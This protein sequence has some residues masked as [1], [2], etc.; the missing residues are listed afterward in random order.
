M[1]KRSRIAALFIMLSIIVGIMPM[2]AVSAETG[3]AGVKI[4]YSVDGENFTEISGSAIPYVSG[5]SR[6]Q[7]EIELPDYTKYVYVKITGTP[8][9][10][11]AP[12][13]AHYWNNYRGPGG[14][15]ANDLIGN[16]GT[17]ATNSNQQCDCDIT[18]DKDSNG[19]FI[20]PIKSENGDIYLYFKDSS[21]NT[22]CYCLRFTAKQE[23]LTSFTSSCESTLGDVVFVGGAAANNDNGTITITTSRSKPSTIR[24]LG[25][26]SKS[27]VGTSIFMLPALGNSDKATDK[28]LFSFRADHGGKIY[29]LSDTECGGVYGGETDGWTCVNNG[30]E[31]AGISKTMVDDKAILQTSRAYNDYTN[32]DYFAWSIE[33]W[34]EPYTYE[35]RGYNLYRLE[36]PGVDGDT[37]LDT[38]DPSKASTKSAW[39]MV[40]AYEKEF[41]PGDLVEIKGMNHKSPDTTVFVKWD[42]E[43]IE[44]EKGPVT[45]EYSVDNNEFLT[46][47]DVSDSNRELTVELPE[48]AKYA[49]VKLTE[50]ENANPPSSVYT[51]W[52]IRGEDYITED[53]LVGTTGAMGG[54]A[55][56]Q[57][58]VPLDAQTSGDTYIVPIKNENGTLSFVYGGYDYSIKFVAKQPRLTELNDYT[59][60]ENSKK[61]IFVGGA[62]ANNDNGTLTESSAMG[63][64]AQHIRGIGNISPALIGASIFMMP[65]YTN[66]EGTIF[67]FRADCGGKVVVMND[68][69]IT[70]SD[71]STWELENNGTQ[72]DAGIISGSRV[73]KARTVNNYTNVGDY[74]AISIAWWCQG[75]YGGRDQLNT[76]RVSDPGLYNPTRSNSSAPSS[77]SDTAK[78]TRGAYG[79]CYCYS[80]DFAAGE[81]VE[82]PA[83]GNDSPDAAIFV[84]WNSD[85]QVGTRWKS[86]EVVS[87]ESDD[88]F[89]IK[90]KAKT[91]LTDAPADAM[92]YA[93][94]YSH[95]GELLDVYKTAYESGET[96]VTKHF[97]KD[98]DGTAPAYAKLYIWSGAEPISE[99]KK[100]LLNSKFD[101]D[102]IKVLAIGNSFSQDCVRRLRDIAAADDITITSYN[103][104]LAGRN[105]KG[106]YDAWN[107]TTAYR[108]QPEGVSPNP[109]TNITLKEFAVLEDWDYVMLQ[110]TTHYN[111][112][113]AGLWN[114]NPSDTENYWTTLKNG[115]AEYAPN[116]KR[117]VNATWT[118][119][120]ELSANVNDGMFDGGTPD[121]RGAYLAALLPNEQI[122]ADFYSTETRADG[123]K[124]FIPVGV[125]V[126]YLIRYYRFPEYVGDLDGT[127][128]NSSTTRAVYRDTTCHLTDNVGRVLAGLVWYEMLTGIPA[129]ENGY[130][131]DKLSR[132]DMEK[133]K[134]AAHYACQNYATYNPAEITPIASETYDAEITKSK[135][136]ADATIVI[137]H[138]DGSKSTT[139]YLGTEFE[140]NN[141][142][143]TV[144]IIGKNVTTQSDASDW[145]EIFDGAHGRL[146]FASHS[147]YHEY[148]G[149]T[150]EAHT[151]YFSGV[152]KEYPAGYM[153]QTIANERTRLNGLFP[154]ERILAFVKPGVTKPDGITTQLSTE[155]RQMIRDHYIAMRDTGGGVDTIPPENDY[156][157]KSLMAK[158]GECELAD[159]QAGLTSAI[160]KKGLLVYLFHAIEN[161]ASNITS[162]RSDVSV[163]LSDIGE[164]VAEGKVWSAKFDEAMQYGKEYGANP[165]ATVTA[166][167][168]ANNM[169]VS[170]TDEISKID[171]D[172]VGQFKGREMYD[173][174][175]TVKAQI[176]FDWDYVKL[177]QNYCN[178]AEIAKTF[179]EDGIRYA[180]L[181]VVPDQAAATVTEATAN[182]YISSVSYGGTAISDFDP[183][184][185]YYNI[186]LPAGTAAAPTL[187]CNKGSAV[188]TQATLSDGE[189][190]GFITFA[191]IKYEI[192]FSVK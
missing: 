116:A 170:V 91:E 13:Y 191:G 172:E 14:A 33:W 171:T 97:D 185:L 62:A 9:G 102:G 85:M 61:V 157:V 121:S 86:A 156:Q 173:Y 139:E 153:T 20:I 96:L 51:E 60:N 42:E 50:G 18:A 114:V 186:S 147:Y 148:M 126:D 100:L 19:N 155:A 176:P 25:N 16:K 56:W 58:M 57:T 115:I 27:L 149:Q 154:N 138:D 72:E 190:S 169:T 168:N 54:N 163:L 137:V 132:R 74:Y 109:E 123:E 63:N 49:Y 88:Y 38:S 47:E 39:A 120:D 140:K 23:R 111:A 188:I 4:S 84:I 40:Y 135:N 45:V 182:D 37:T 64:N 150:D 17:I 106:H 10:W 184:K 136:G 66:T 174:P 79:M 99:T 65:K 34:L 41:E 117:L 133:L 98:Y 175:L 3:N 28:T 146:N 152:A 142:N 177:T 103:A 151:N 12:T 52:E 92:F 24:A 118:P 44:V 130:Q 26:I 21:D 68:T 55:Q 90:A 145:Q 77:A 70:N 125:A 71:Y 143:G 81:L 113:D 160:T 166:N 15:D 31:A 7:K 8:S 5:S 73:V 11:T 162:A 159:W 48:G 144:A 178:R 107:G 83:S 87:E 59:V 82:I 94:I 110:G 122:G 105:L 78:S 101:N 164:K 141:L 22:V 89:T 32:T 2:T 53:A 187:S 161:S 124:A 30:V 158:V 192:H 29:V 183:A 128:D 75:N 129:T 46:L 180:Y 112:Y 167:Y 127:L 93:A 181:N 35:R 108:V 134:A 67:S 95:N 1:K 80:K 119:I 36:T 189:G 6:F 43:Y 69:E 76:F 104:Y 179:V 131:R 165:V